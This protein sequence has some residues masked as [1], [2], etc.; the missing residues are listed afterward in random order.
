MLNQKGLSMIELLVVMGILVTLAA[1]AI[2]NY[3]N[4]RTRANRGEA[5][6]ALVDEAQKAERFFTRN[7]TYN[8][9]GLEAD[10]EGLTDHGLYTIAYTGAATTY[11]I[12]A[13]ATGSQASDT[14]CPT[15]T[16]TQTGAKTPAGC[17]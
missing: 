17:W 14:D 8:D 2:P 13:T 9:A 12:V 4:Y 11:T 1:I 16:I 7:N 10:I 6:A 5:R 3:M 15:L